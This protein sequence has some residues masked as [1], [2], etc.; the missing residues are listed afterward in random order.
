MVVMTTETRS[1]RSETTLCASVALDHPATDVADFVLDWGNDH[2][3]R[4]HVRGFTCTP[5]GRATPGQQL[6]EELTFAGLRFTTPTVVDRASALSAG[7][8]GGSPTVTVT[9]VRTVVAQGPSS[10]VLTTTT[11]LRFGGLLRPFVPLLTPSYR[12]LDASD[13]AGLPAVLAHLAE[14]ERDRV[15]R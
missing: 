1:T 4:S 14:L 6:V 13:L 5:P 11:R 15:Q 2:L 8:S 12:R 9:G 3:W 10:C 7:Y